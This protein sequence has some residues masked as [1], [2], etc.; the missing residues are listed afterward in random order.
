MERER[1]RLE[2]DEEGGSGDS[3]AV[4]GQLVVSSQGAC[5]DGTQRR[6]Q[7]WEGSTGQ[8]T[9]PCHLWS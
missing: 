5:M 1:S 3:G 9:P 2:R 6:R 7:T 4:Q 8:M